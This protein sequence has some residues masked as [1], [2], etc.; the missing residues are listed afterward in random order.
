MTFATLIGVVLVS[1]ALCWL[2]DKH[3]AAHRKVS[4]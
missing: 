4:R 3:A 2:H 1:L